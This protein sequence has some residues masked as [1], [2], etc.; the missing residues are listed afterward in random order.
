MKMQVKIFLVLP[1]SF[2]VTSQSSF[3]LHKQITSR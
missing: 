2:Y 1:D 3:I